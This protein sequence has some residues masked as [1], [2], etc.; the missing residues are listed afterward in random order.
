MMVV[1]KF[2]WES[3]SQGNLCAANIKPDEG[4]WQIH[5]GFMMVFVR[6]E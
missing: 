2:I 5:K 6:K 3:C 1:Q 4:R